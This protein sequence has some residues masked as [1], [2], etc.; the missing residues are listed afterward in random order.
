MMTHC[1]PSGIPIESVQ[2]PHC[3]NHW[4]SCRPCSGLM[5]YTCPLQH[6]GLAAAA[7]RSKMPATLPPHSVPH[8]VLLGDQPVH[9]G[10]M[11]TF[12][13]HTPV[14]ALVI[15]PHNVPWGQPAQ[16]HVSATRSRS[17]PIH[18]IKA[19]QLP[20]SQR[21]ATPVWQ[22]HCPTPTS[23]LAESRLQAFLSC[24]HAEAAGNQKGPS[25]SQLPQPLEGHQT[26]QCW[27]P[28]EGA[29]IGALDLC[30]VPRKSWRGQRKSIGRTMYHRM[31]SEHRWHIWQWAGCWP[32]TLYSAYADATLRW[33]LW[34]R[35]LPQHM[36]FLPQSQLQHQ[37][38]TNTVCPSGQQAHT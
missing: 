36:Q 31:C 19:M 21:D 3:N 6:S 16:T 7:A 4:R 28:S 12:V 15:P 37:P 26:V 30:P 24:K 33:Q 5:H 35:H 27:L 34:V 1:T 29:S 20:F 32:H 11:C 22:Q 14:S 8:T 10:C 2:N 17:P 23:C 38:H 13:G 9:T 25:C 18:T